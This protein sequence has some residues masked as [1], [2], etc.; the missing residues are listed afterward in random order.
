MSKKKISI[1]ALLL[2][3]FMIFISS[4]N[5]NHVTTIETGK[6]NYLDENEGNYEIQHSKLGAI[7]VNI[8]GDYDSNVKSVPAS[9][10]CNIDRI[11]KLIYMDGEEVLGEKDIKYKKPVGQLMQPTK[12]GYT[13]VQWVNKNGELV[14]EKSIIDSTV[15]YYIYASWNIIISE[16]TVLPNGGTW[17][18]TTGEQKFNLAFN[19][20][21]DIEDPTRIGYT[22]AGWEITGD[23]S[24]IENKKYTMGV[25]DT[26]I[27]AKWTPNVYNLTIDPNS[28]TYNGSTNILK[29]TATFD[30]ETK[31]ATPEKR[32]YT[33]VGWTLDHGRLKDDNKTFILDYPGD[34]TLIANWK[35]NNYKY[36]VYHK[37][38]NANDS[39]FT[40]YPND[41]LAGQAEYKSVLTPL[42]KTYTGFN[43][44][45][46]QTLTIDVD[47]DPPTKNVVNYLYYRKK[48]NL[49]LNLSGGSL[50]SAT[51]RTL[52]YNETVTINPP[53]R[54]GYTFQG[55]S[56]TAGDGTFNGTTFRMGLQNTSF[57]ANWQARQYVLTYN[58][59]GGKA[60]SGSSSQNVTYGQQYGTLK[61]TSKPGN[62][63]EGWY[64]SLS[65]GEKITATSTHKWA[66]NITV[67]ARWSNSAPSQPA[68]NIRYLNGGSEHGELKSNREVAYIDVVTYDREDDAENKKPT[69]TL[70][71]VSGKLCND[72]N[73]RKVSTSGNV[74]KYEI[75][76]YT[77]GVALLKTVATDSTGLYTTSNNIIQIYGDDSDTGLLPGKYTNT[78]FD[79]DYLD[80]I[81][82]CYISEYTFTVRFASGH[83]N[84]SSSQPDRMIVYGLTT[85][86]TVVELYEWHGNM[87]SDPHEVIDRKTNRKD[88]VQIRFYTYS[89]HDDCARSATIRY[90]AK[91][92]F[93]I[94]LLQNQ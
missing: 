71:C 49:T 11:T 6:V 74:T 33:F 45:P 17:N 29:T 92:K 7:S 4:T 54:T 60:V 80:Y 93:D 10:K 75:T 94:S 61:S 73:I 27:K 28:G 76:A 30:A 39:G 35:I 40:I 23:G 32:G 36:I 8:K 77:F 67:Y 56:R 51:S 24:T 3:I 18:G 83:S 48:A 38:E 20:T 25:E 87:R 46:Q 9:C 70:T 72:I 41:T 47:T 55:W 64:T 1:V 26:T 19:S 15:N 78:T 13:F 63:F 59:N 50:S 34:A 69:I 68:M 2:I 81:E 37:Q 31:L 85:S 12:R 91:Y 62:I 22:F 52:K 21:K 66:N 42:V 86:N 65:G 79:S 57:T 5:S 53:T 90:R 88:I 84:S 82:G 14:D 89:P 43:S 58:V 16:L 44:P